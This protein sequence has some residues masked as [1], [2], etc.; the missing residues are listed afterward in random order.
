MER[1]EWREVSG[2]GEWRGG[3]ERGEWREVSGE[4]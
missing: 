4:R 1:D 2:E 3:A